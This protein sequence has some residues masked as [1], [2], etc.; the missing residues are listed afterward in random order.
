MVTRTRGNCWGCVLAWLCV[1]WFLGF[2][3]KPKCSY[4]KNQSLRAVVK[5][6][7][8]VRTQSQVIPLL[9]IF[10]FLSGPGASQSLLGVKISG[11]G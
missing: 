6:Y 9:S 4:L 2:R 7:G 10:N 11:V 1:L 5:R 8:V 3:K